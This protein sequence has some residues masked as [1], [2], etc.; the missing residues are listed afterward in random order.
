MEGV[1][2]IHYRHLHGGGGGRCQ[3]GEGR[4][5]VVPIAKYGLFGS[6]WDRFLKS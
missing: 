3:E 1:P 2:R 5:G 6:M 4:G